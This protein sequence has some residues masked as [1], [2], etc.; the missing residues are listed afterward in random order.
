MT[1]IFNTGLELFQNGFTSIWNLGVSNPLIS[2]TIFGSVISMVLEK[3]S[4]MRGTLR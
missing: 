1:E 4:H 3:F 2:L